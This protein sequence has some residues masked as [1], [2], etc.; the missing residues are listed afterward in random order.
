MSQ[1]ARSHGGGPL[2]VIR[3]GPQAAAVKAHVS[4]QQWRKIV[5]LARKRGV[6]PAGAVSGNPRPLQERTNS[7]LLAQA[8]KMVSQAYDPTL[9]Q[10]DAQQTQ[11]NALSDKRKADN[12]AYQ[13]WL[14]GKQA[15]YSAQAAA[16]Q[17]QYQTYLDNLKASTEQ[18]HQQ[19]QT[20][21]QA[22][23]QGQP[24]TVSNIAQ[25]SAIQGL[26]NDTTKAVGLVDNARQ[27][28]AAM[29]PSLQMRQEANR[30]AVIGQGQAAE[31]KRI[32]DLNTG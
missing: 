14:M 8:Q 32:S 30:Q 1:H 23:V 31:A 17:Q 19:A 24:G 7:S 20:G 3:Y 9:K 2:D 28:T 15:E 5:A 12:A 6:T 16:S 10:L 11:L 27:Q 21:A 22:A 4:P 26:S 25:S 18:A 29:I 13:Q